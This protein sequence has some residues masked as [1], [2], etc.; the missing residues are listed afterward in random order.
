MS[1]SVRLGQAVLVTH[2][3]VF[4]IISLSVWFAPD[5][6]ERD[7][8]F[9]ISSFGVTSAFLLITLAVWGIASRA[10][11]AWMTLWVLPVFYLWL[12]V[13]NGTPAHLAFAAIAVGALWVTR[14]PRV[15][16]QSPARS[17]SVGASS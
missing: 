4:A 11:W 5:P 12:V 1:T 8:T 16:Y 9:L 14:P 6:F 15:R 7:A 2:G 17:S 10:R 3:L 13:A